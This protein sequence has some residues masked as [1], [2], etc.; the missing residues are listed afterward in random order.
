MK[1]NEL[2]ELKQH[3]ETIPGNSLLSP[4]AILTQA[5][6]ELG[7]TQQ[8]ASRCLCLSIKIITAIERDEYKDLH[9]LSYIRGYLRAYANLLNFS[10]EKVLQAFEQQ[11]YVNNTDRS[12]KIQKHKTSVTIIQKEHIARVMSYILLIAFVAMSFLWWQD[13]QEHGQNILGKLRQDFSQLNIHS[14]AKTS[15]SY[16]KPE[17]LFTDLPDNNIELNPNNVFGQQYQFNSQ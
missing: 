9:G 2:I 4:G 7:L 3:S 11:G 8:E 5:R 14:V 15:D 1:Q 13:H 10:P 17:M 16:L 6:H 12:D